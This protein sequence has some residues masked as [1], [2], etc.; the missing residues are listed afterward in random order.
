MVENIFL[1]QMTLFPPPYR[2]IID[3]CS[4]LSQ[5][6]DEPHR[7]SVYSTLWKKIDEL[8]KSKA[9]VV[10]SEIKDEV[11]DDNL[12][13]WFQQNGCEVLDVDSIVQMNVTK[14]VNEHPELLNFTNM[15][16][17]GDAFLVATA[18]KYN[19]A[20]ITEENKN[21]PKKIPKICEAYGIPCYNVTELAEKEGWTF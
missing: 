8:V 11:E 18:M 21:S 10:C 13:L 2:Y 5:K 6:S 19:I 14:I 16:S 4:I 3:T 15:K 17:S 9:I 12:K 20:V 7:R 1:E